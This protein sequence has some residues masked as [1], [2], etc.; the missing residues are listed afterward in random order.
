[1]LYNGLLYH[2]V[3]GKNVLR[4]IV[5]IN[6]IYI[7]TNLVNSECKKEQHFVSMRIVMKLILQ[8][9]NPS[10]IPYFCFLGGLFRD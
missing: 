8:V 7:S 3:W 10:I 4:F 5:M 2:L 9:F 6:D 1:M